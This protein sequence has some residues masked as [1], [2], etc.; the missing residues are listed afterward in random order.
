MK[1]AKLNC[2]VLMIISLY[3]YIYI[4]IYIDDGINSLDYVREEILRK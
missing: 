3:I 4:Y 2:L 1:F